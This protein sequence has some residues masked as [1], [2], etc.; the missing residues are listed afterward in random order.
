MDKPIE[1]LTEEMIL[2]IKNRSRLFVLD[3]INEPSVSD[4]LYTEN[5]ML[6]GA[7]IALEKNHDDP[8]GILMAIVSELRKQIELYKLALEMAAREVINN[9]GTYGEQV[10]RNN[11]KREWIQQAREY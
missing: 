4:F 6:I 5:A 9:E 8:K 1:Q 11:K 10:K 2:E 3:N 7:S